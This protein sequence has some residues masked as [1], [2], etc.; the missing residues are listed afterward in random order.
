MEQNRNSV[1]LPSRFQIGDYVC[2]AARVTGVH[3][4]EGK[5]NYDVIMKQLPADEGHMY[6]LDAYYG[7][8]ESDYVSYPPRSQRVDSKYSA[9]MTASITA[10]SP[11]AR[12]ADP[13]E[14]IIS[15]WDA[16]CDRSG[17]PRA[18]PRFAIGDTVIIAGV[19]D[20][21]K[22]RICCVCIHP[23]GVIRYQV[24]DLLG[25]FAGDQMKL[26]APWS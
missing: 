5:V 25:E 1:L 24:E 12:Y 19:D 13:D 14:P 11:T 20:T 17:I 9:P 3:F 2:V 15:D 21:A 10:A 7:G 8:I 18:V 26:V 22:H 23:N 16:Y 6:S 4:T